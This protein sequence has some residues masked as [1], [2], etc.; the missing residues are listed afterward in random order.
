MLTCIACAITVFAAMILSYL[1]YHGEHGEA[2]YLMIY[3][4]RPTCDPFSA[5]IEFR[6]QNLTFNVDPRA[7][8]LK[9]YNIYNGRGPI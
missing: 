9:E 6:R 8:Q 4:V 7:E 1:S 5:G 3:T 2:A